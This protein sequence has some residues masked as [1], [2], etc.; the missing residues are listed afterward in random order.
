MDSP[1]RGQGHKDTLLHTSRKVLVIR[2][3][4]VQYDN[5]EIYYYVM[6]NVNFIYRKVQDKRFSTNNK[7]P[8]PPP[9]PPPAPTPKHKLKLTPQDKHTNTFKY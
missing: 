9:P 6:T 8:P 1:K 3:A 5:S 2:N 7:I 4:H